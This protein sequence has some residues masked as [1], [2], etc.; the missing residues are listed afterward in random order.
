V[1][2]DIWRLF[3]DN[4]EFIYNLKPGEKQKTSQTAGFAY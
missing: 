2:N 4:D 1:A 3:P